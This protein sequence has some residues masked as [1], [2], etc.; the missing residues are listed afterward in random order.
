[1]NIPIQI[2]TEDC[3]C[4]AQWRVARVHKIEVSKEQQEKMDAGKLAPMGNRLETVG[5]VCGEHKKKL[6]ASDHDLKFAFIG[7]L[8]IGA[9]HTQFRP[10][11]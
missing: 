7:A 6:E 10:H 8:P 4:W 2:C 5:H 3:Q 1:M 11:R 9:H